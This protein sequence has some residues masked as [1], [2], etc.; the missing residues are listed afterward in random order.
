MEKDLALWQKLHDGKHL[1][2]F[3]HIA[4]P[5]SSAEELD[6]YKLAN[7]RGWMQARWYIES[8]YPLSVALGRTFA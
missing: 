1:S 2:P 7:F 5:A 4:T 3:E 6:G 8:G